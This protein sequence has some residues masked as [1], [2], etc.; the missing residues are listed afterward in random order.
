MIPTLHMLGIPHTITSNE[1]SH[2]AFTG[3]VLRFPK[4]TQPYGYRVIEYS[5]GESES[6]AEEKVQIF[7]KDRLFEYRESMEKEGKTL[8]DMHGLIATGFLGEL[9]GRLKRRVQPGD[10]I[11]HPFGLMT[12]RIAELFPEQFHV[13]TGIGYNHSWA[14]YRIYESYAWWHYHQ[15]YEQRQG[16]DYEFVA[17]NYYDVNEWEFN[18][19]PSSDLVYFGRITQD[20]GMDI[21]KEIARRVPYRV[22]LCGSGDPSPWLSSDTPNLIYREPLKGLER[23]KF[24]GNAYACLMPTRYTEPFGGSGVEGMLCGTPLISSDHGAFSETVEEGRTGFRCKTL[25]Q[26]LSAIKA[27]NLLDRKTVRS[28]AIDKYSLTVV[29]E[30]YDRIFR[31][32]LDLKYKKGWYTV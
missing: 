28:R 15:G 32:I 30:K 1:F 4:M 18:S 29:G 26:W 24:L 13:E 23:S 25:G 27:V 5:N 19:S 8:W 16:H 3:K 14:P 12:Q 17:P 10:I 21:I 31:Q 11:C 6:L 2:C 7:T 22:I 9:V 20:K